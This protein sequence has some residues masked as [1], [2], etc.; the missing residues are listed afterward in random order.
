LPFSMLSSVKPIRCIHRKPLLCVSLSVLVLATGCQTHAP[1]TSSPVSVRPTAVIPA[2][3][4]QVQSSALYQQAR[5]DCTRHD[6]RLAADHLQMLART[7]GLAPDALAF[8]VQ[9]REICLRDAGIP[10][11]ASVVV[12]ASAPA[13]SPADADCGPRA[14]LLV[15]QKLGVK[16]NVETLRKS[17]GTTAKGTTMAG[18]QQAAQKLGLKAEGVQVSREA[19]PDIAPPALV[20]LH[21]DHFAVLTG[22]RGRGEDAQCTIRD[23][24]HPGEET[25]LQEKLLQQSSGVLLLI[26]R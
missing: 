20:W 9:Q 23:P 25:W 3:V 8:V 21:R 22:I 24:N 2:A 14:L 4:T 5:Q 15:C 7:P 17:A 19:L 1:H 13:R 12:T 11:P 10:S 26:H 18:L 6:F 16:T